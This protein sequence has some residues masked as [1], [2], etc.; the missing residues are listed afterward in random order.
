[1]TYHKYLLSLQLILLT[2]P[3][4][5]EMRTT[6]IQLGEAGPFQGCV[7]AYGHFSTIHPGHIRYLRHARN[8]GKQ[9][10]VALIG[11]GGSTSYPFNQQERA[12]ALSLLGIA[13]AVLLLQANELDQA[14]AAL[15]AL[16]LHTHMMSGDTEQAV[17]V[18]AE[19]L[20]IQDFH[21]N[22]P[23]LLLC[24]ETSLIRNQVCVANFVLISEF[25]YKR[26]KAKM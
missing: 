23:F 25:P 1:M 5:P 21:G 11:D 24:S 15:Q 16:G 2:L 18:V 13:D 20:G 19:Q 9:L 8:L 26:S 22:L 3:F 4:S 14:I 7:L 6:C 10:L 12:E 17:S